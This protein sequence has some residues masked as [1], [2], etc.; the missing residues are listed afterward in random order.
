MVGSHLPCLMYMTCGQSLEEHK[1]H[2]QAFSSAPVWKQLQADPQY[3]DNMIGM[4]RVL[5]KRT[6]ASQI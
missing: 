6:K 4:I 1:K 5:L 3:K 2:W